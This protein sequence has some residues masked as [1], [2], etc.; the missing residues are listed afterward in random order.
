M[1]AQLIE[2]L[3]LMPHPEGGYYHETYRSKLKDREEK[4]LFSSIY[5]L[6]ETGN[7]SHFHRI[8]SDELWYFQGGDAL[9][10]HMIDAA[11]SY[12]TVKLGL[13]V[14]NGEVPQFL[15]PKQTIFASSVE[16]E[17]EWSLVGCMVSPA[18]TFEEFKLFSQDE[19]LSKYPEHEEVIRKYALS[20]VERPSE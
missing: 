8:E 17:S 16:G 18:F 9:T 2:R 12:Q 7:I 14:A 4:A 11:G 6:L 15:V 3:K 13:D 5:F 10:I 1:K 19:L 20:S